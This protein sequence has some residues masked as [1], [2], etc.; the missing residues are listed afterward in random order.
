VRAQDLLEGKVDAA[1]LAGKLVVFGTDL[2]LLQDYHVTPVGRIWG[3]E[4]LATEISNLL[5]GDSL[6]RPAWAAWAEAALMLSAFAV[7]L[8]TTLRLRPAV[9]LAAALAAVA[10]LAL[11]VGWFYVARGLSL[12][13]VV[14]A[15]LA[16]AT[17]LQA[18]LMRYVIE[19]RRKRTLH[20]ALS[21]YLSPELTRQVSE[22]PALLSLDGKAIELTVL[23]SDI[24]GFTS[25]S[26]TMTPEGLTSFLHEYLTPMTDAVFETGGTLDKYI[27]DAVMAFWGAPLDE[28]DHAGK[29][30]EAALRM[31][32]RL[33]TLQAGWRSRGLPPI[34]IGVGLNTGPMRVGNMG[35]DK[36]LSYTVMGDNVNLGSRLEGLTKHYGV[37]LIVSGA[38]W[39]KVA[40]RFH[41]RQL[42]L[43]KV[44]GKDQ[45]VPIH[46]IAG[47]GDAPPELAAAHAVW[48]A[49]RAAYLARD[50]DVAE[51]GFRAWAERGDA[52]ARHYL[53]AI[54]EFR[55]APPPPGWEGVTKMETK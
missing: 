43:V 30:C 31:L 49:A 51:A 13:L 45:A 8:A 4:I 19:E 9:A 44:K 35:S 34:E 20:T 14:P 48:A 10:A 33:A 29:G 15:S 27:G 40:G 6:R 52:T 50:W 41:G 17:F 38:T 36:R 54:A 42:D 26:E 16:A 1:A 21:L 18:S 39:E 28:P 55:A 22:N 12:S 32:E 25:I 23:F 46:E 53:E 7:V 11:V 5:Q 2:L 24:R 3:T 47:R 37:R